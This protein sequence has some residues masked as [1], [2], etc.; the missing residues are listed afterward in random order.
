M[1]KKYFRIWYYSAMFRDIESLGT[2]YNPEIVSAMEKLMMADITPEIME[3]VLSVDPQIVKQ[4][5]EELNE[6]FHL[7][8]KKDLNHSFTQEINEF[9][10]NWTSR[11]PDNKYGEDKDISRH[12]WGCK[13]AG[14]LNEF[15][16]FHATIYASIFVEKIDI[17]RILRLND[18]DAPGKSELHA[19]LAIETIPVIARLLALGY[20]FNELTL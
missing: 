9:F 11:L 10:K 12:R 5:E 4:K 19:N 8:Y 16:S 15:R 1:L 18:E 13:E 3:R 2:P 20:T 14:K 17:G 7:F 6:E